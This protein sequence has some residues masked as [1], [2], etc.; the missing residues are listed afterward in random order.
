[1]PLKVYGGQFIHTPV[2]WTQ[3]PSA[4]TSNSEM[5]PK[6]C[7]TKIMNLNVHVKKS[8]QVPP[9]HLSP[10]SNIPSHASI[11]SSPNLLDPH[12]FPMSPRICHPVFCR[13][14]LYVVT[15]VSVL[16]SLAAPLVALPLRRPPLLLR[17]CRSFIAFSISLLL[18]NSP[19]SH[20]G[21]SS[22]VKSLK[23]NFSSVGNSILGKSYSGRVHIFLNACIV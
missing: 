15:F 2:D 4:L 18:T 19:R 16:L 7:K 5:Y 13:R 17:P 1:M 14:V 20:S 3:K 10:S 22:T 8:K 6:Y 12:I 23:T 9:P 21:M 11:A